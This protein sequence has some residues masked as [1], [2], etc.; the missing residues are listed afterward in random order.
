MTSGSAD[1]RPPALRRILRRL[2]SIPTPLILG[3]CLVLAMIVLWWQGALT[4][5][6]DTVREASLGLALA[7]LA[8]FVVGLAV[9][10]YRWNALVKMANQGKSDL[11]RATE[12]FLASILINYA[13]PVGLAVPSRAALTKRALGLD[14]NATGTIALWEIAAD[15]LVLGFASLFWFLFANGALPAVLDELGDA[16]LQFAILGIVLF[17]LGAVAIGV[18]LK[19]PT[20]RT[21]VTTL[22]RAIALA[23]KQRP[24]AAFEVLIIT[25]TFWILQAV[26][27]GV[28]IKAM[29]VDVSFQL[30]HGLTSV[31]FLV[32]ILSPIPGGAV[33]RES[34]MYVVARLS[35]V[36]GGEV[37]AAAVLYRMALFVSI[38]ILFAGIR[39]WIKIQSGQSAHRVA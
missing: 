9:Q 15:V 8:L 33:V 35:E 11:P 28:F 12:A 14:S 31:P 2:L 22:L 3:I 17:V 6:W 32:G 4:E 16:A 5:F 27:L 30:L 7:G 19:R 26:T 23:P 13:A 34:L 21:K 25:I 20:L 37:V 29:N 24:A 18:L 1:G 39:L 38:P 10:C 36:P